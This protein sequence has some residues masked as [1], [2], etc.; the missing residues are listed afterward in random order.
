MFELTPFILLVLCHVLGDFYLQSE[1]LVAAKNQSAS[2]AFMPHVFH[3]FVHG[4][5]VLTALWFAYSGSIQLLY[6]AAVIFVTHLLIDFTKSIFNNAQPLL[7]FVV[8]QLTHLIVLV[9]IAF[10][11]G[12]APELQLS[13]AWEGTHQYAFLVMALG[14]LFV[15]KPASVLIRLV[16]NGLHSGPSTEGLTL[17][18]GGQILGY[19]ERM[20]ILILILLDQFAAI[21]FVIAAKSVLRFSDLNRLREASDG[22][23]PNPL[24]LTEYVLVGTFM[25][26]LYVLVVGL[27]VRLIW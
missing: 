15:L 11:I 14:V 22:K 18:Q 4:F 16:L 12:G 26:F 8:D 17:P 9:S 21:G 13:F 10:Y 5:L 1:R 27:L 24:Y 25:S 20:I 23:S 7:A 19:L 3:A 2:K 6:I